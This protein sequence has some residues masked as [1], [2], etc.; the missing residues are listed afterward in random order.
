MR[1]TLTL[2]YAILICLGIASL[3]CSEAFA[4]GKLDSFKD[5]AGVKKQEAPASPAV[6]EKQP[7]DAESAFSDDADE[8][9]NIW[10]ELVGE[11]FAWMFTGIGHAL[12]QALFTDQGVRYR[13][14]PYNKPE[15][16]YHS[17]ERPPRA[18]GILRTEYQRVSRDLY[19]FG[20]RL[21]LRMP[22][23]WDAS[24][25]GIYYNERLSTGRHDRM[26]F[27]RFRLNCLCSPLE[28]QVLIRLGGG[29]AA[30]GDRIGFDVGIEGDWF[31]K[32]PF[33][34]HG[35]VSH[36][37]IG[38]GITDIDMGLGVFLGPVELVLGYRGLITRDE[39]LD[40]AFLSLGLWF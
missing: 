3:V 30:L 1:K 9:D 18:P 39:Q 31:F 25:S 7:S 26:S 12:N 8:D 22:S 20:W 40:G 23:G 19:G 36:S 27:G 32:K 21:T 28:E 34:Y 13:A 2:I 38:T 15:Y 6:S 35:Q 24:A 16:A 33:A 4:D 37:F 10:N 14:Y 29:F 5:S 11:M 17:N